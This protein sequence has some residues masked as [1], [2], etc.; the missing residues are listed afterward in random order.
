MAVRIY[1]RRAM[2]VGDIDE[3]K[4]KQVMQDTESNA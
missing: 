2:T 3:A 4:V 1:R